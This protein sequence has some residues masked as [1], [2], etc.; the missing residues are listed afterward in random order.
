L[1]EIEKD[2]IKIV[3]DNIHRN[4]SKTAK[5]LGIDRKTLLSK[6]KRYNIQ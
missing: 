1:N 2:Y 4:R 5:I 3:F 6:L